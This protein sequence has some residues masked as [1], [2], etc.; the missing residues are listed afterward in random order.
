MKSC[1]GEAKHRGLCSVIGIL[2]DTNIKDSRYD[3]E[4]NKFS[5]RFFNKSFENI[6]ETYKRTDKEGRIL[7]EDIDILHTSVLE[8][9]E[10]L[11]QLNLTITDI[12]VTDIN[13]EDGEITVYM[14][15]R[16]LL[17]VTK[18]EN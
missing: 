7:M 15:V 14:Q 4:I 11:T 6:Y 9:E 16:I 1:N 12:E 17:S 18:C 13:V 2:K 3:F 5:P 10:E 8:K